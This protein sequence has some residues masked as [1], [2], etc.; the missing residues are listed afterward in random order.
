MSS[1]AASRIEEDCVREQELS[2]LFHMRHY[3]GSHDRGGL[4]AI[5]E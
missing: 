2:A 1:L 3:T 4:I 5:A